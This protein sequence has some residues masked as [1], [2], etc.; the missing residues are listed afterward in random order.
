MKLGIEIGTDV[1]RAA[2]LDNDGQPHLVTLANSQTCL[3]TLARQTMHGLL[4]GD[5]A[6]QTLAGNSET[7]VCGCTRL[8][9]KT[10]DQLASL[11]ARLPYAARQIDGEVV[12][13]LL[14]AEARISDIYGKIAKMLVDQ[15]SQSLQRVIDSVVLTVPASAE[16]RFRVQAKTAAEAQGIRIERLINQPTASLLAAKHHGLW[17]ESKAKVAIVHCGGSSLDISIADQGTE[18]YIAATAGDDQLGGDDFA[19]FVAKKLNEHFR[20]QAQVDI[21]ATGHSKIAAYGLQGAADQ[22][23]QALNLAPKTMFTLDHGG[24]FGRDLYLTLYRTNVIAWLEP[25]LQKIDALVKQTLTKAKL[26]ARHID[27]VLLTGEWAFIPG[28]QQAIADS[29][30]RP[31]SKL[32]HKNPAILPV[33]GA[34]LASASTSERIWDVTPYPLGINCY[35]GKHERFSPI[36]PANSRIPTKAIGSKKAFTASYQTRYANQTSV[37]LDI[38]QYRGRQDPNPNGRSPV[39]PDQCE[40]LGTWTFDDLSPK[41]GQCAAFTVTFEV[42]QDGILHLFAQE[43]TTGHSLTATVNRN[44]G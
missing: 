23:L 7:T 36:V 8:M 21:L 25:L 28:L 24:G 27:H 42:D 32:I 12:C 35:Y 5:D 6:A 15:A 4:I 18:T 11:L 43:T 14:Y 39:S 37:T 10:D 20:Q 29:F 44:I 41:R 17:P 9:G 34:A 1:A 38:L 3:S 19:W 22:A 33:F 2:F 30:Q 40:V 13:D 26:Q 16:D 31:V